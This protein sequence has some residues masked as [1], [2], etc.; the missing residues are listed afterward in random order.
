MFWNFKFVVYV[1]DIVFD[2][3]RVQMSKRHTQQKLKPHNYAWLI[4]FVVAEQSSTTRILNTLSRHTNIENVH[5]KHCTLRKSQVQNAAD[6]HSTWN[7]TGRTF[8][9][10]TKS[11]I[12]MRE[13]KFNA[14]DYKR[15]ILHI[16]HDS[17]IAKVKVIC[18]I[19]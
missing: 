7:N 18:W 3:S 14:F 19:V 4:H 1:R 8:Y 2:I 16:Q 9:Y 13:T 12:H 5:Q 10:H 15:T 6:V 17:W 11:K